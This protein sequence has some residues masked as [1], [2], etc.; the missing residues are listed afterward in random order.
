M[1]RQNQCDIARDLMP[2]AI[3]GVCAEGSRRFLDEHLQQCPPCQGIYAQMRAAPIPMVTAAPAQEEQAFRQS[4]RCLG[5]RL[6]ALWI[7]LAVLA[8]AFIVLLGISGVQQLL[9]N[10]T[11]TAALDTYTV[12][13]YRQ[14]AMFC[15]NLSAAFPRQT[16]N[17]FMCDEKVVTGAENRTDAEKAVILTYSV[18]Y[19]PEQARSFM[20]AMETVVPQGFMTREQGQLSSPVADFRYNGGLQSNRLCVADGG[21]YLIGVKE[22]VMT[23]Y[24]RPL[25]ILMPDLPVS[26]IRFTD[27]KDTVTLYH[28][29]D[30]IPNHS[31]DRMD[32]YGVPQSGMLSPSDLERF[33]DLIQ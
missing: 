25:T 26:E 6:R 32:E 1:N 19:F 4:L 11:D 7:A 23:S 10:R 9:W 14:D 31:A 33:R 24:G 21:L 27:G 28:W 15:M 29:G 20:E 12:T 8:A 16:Y 2:L 13:F 30:A 17:G 18:S 3:D 5:R 22:Y